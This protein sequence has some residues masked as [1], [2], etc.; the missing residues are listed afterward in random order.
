MS[1]TASRSRG[2]RRA[3]MVAALM[4][5]LGFSTV[6]V[7][8]GAS[9]SV[10]GALVRAWSAELVDRR[11]HRHHHHGAALPRADAHRLADARGAARHGEA[12]RAVGRLCDGA[13]VRVRLDAVHRADPR[14]DPGGRGVRGDGRRRARACSRSIRRGSAFRSCLPRSRSSAFAA[15]FARF[16][17]QL[18]NVERA[19]GVLMI[20]PASPS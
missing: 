14:G 12:G 20:S 2:S 13:C 19:M 4:F 10:V 9:A 3:V 11:G 16:K 8:L 5:V 17:H 6:F 7:A 1:P 18:A 15:L